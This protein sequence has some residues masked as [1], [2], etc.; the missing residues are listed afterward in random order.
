MAEVKE[1]CFAYK[2]STK[3]CTALNA[4]YCAKENCSFYKSEN[5]EKEIKE[6]E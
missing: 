6:D 2:K 5:N 3:R 4:L 1:D